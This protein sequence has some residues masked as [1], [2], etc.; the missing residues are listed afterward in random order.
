MNEAKIM[1]EFNMSS[2]FVTIEAAIRPPIRP[3]NS[4]G[5]LTVRNNPV[6]FIIT[7]PKKALETTISTQ[8]MK[9]KTTK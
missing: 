9:N 7:L 6:T 4:A 8:I 3:K 5:N 2:K 1:Y